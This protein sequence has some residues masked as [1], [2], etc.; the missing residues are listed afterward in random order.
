MFRSSLVLLLTLMA[1]AAAASPAHAVM[2]KVTAEDEPRFRGWAT[3]DT[4]SR[5]QTLRTYVPVWHWDGD[6]WQRRNLGTHNG[7]G[8][9]TRVYRAPYAAGYSWIWT[10]P[11]G[12][13]A[14]RSEHVLVRLTSQSCDGYLFGCAH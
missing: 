13:L 1:L 12:W 10:Q 7:Q 2:Q 8:V 4:P 5:I 3:L 11:T 14:V 9:S 6:S